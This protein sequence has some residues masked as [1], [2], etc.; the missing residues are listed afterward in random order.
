LGRKVKAKVNKVIYD[1]N[2]AII[3]YEAACW[4]SSTVENLHLGFCDIDF[5]EICIT[6]FQEIIQSSL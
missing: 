3:E 4:Q 2:G 5:D 6:V 1:F